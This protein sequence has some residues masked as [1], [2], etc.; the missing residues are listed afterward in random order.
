MDY[1]RNSSTVDPEVF[2]VPDLLPKSPIIINAPETMLPT[3]IPSWFSRSRATEH[4]LREISKEGDIL[5]YLHKNSFIQSILKCDVVACKDHNWIAC[6]PDS[7]TLLDLSTL[8]FEGPVQYHRASVE[9]KKSVA[10]STI[11][12]TLQ[13]AANDVIC[14]VAECTVFKNIIPH[15]YYG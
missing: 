6:S 12:T 1:P 7:A 3:L 8:P 11:D 15:S 5:K 13:N 9:I 2:Q 4:M 10:F 14:C